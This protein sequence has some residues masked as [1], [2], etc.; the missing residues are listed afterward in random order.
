[1]AELRREIATVTPS[2][3]RLDQ[4]PDGVSLR[5]AV[6]HVDDRGSVCEL[7]DPRWGW[8]DDPLV[9]AYFFTLRPGMVKGWG[10]HMEHEDRYFI[11]YGDLEVV[12]YDDR[13]DSPT[14]G[15]VARIYL[16][17]QHRRLMNI[18]PGIWHANRNVGQRD[19]T[20]I[21]F[22]T[23]PYDHLNPDKYKLPIDTDKIPYSFEE[24]TRGW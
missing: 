7:F 13:A 2:G 15:L 9:Y 8:S 3:E 1:M 20:A 18:P 5:D 24:G 22:P 19:V 4:L 16:S 11:L 17:D 12:L 23:Q 6:V 14:R 21:N 10:M